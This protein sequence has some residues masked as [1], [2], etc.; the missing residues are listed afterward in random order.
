[1]VQPIEENL[2]FILIS[3]QQKMNDGNDALRL[4]AKN[5]SNLV[6]YILNCAIVQT[7]G[8]FGLFGLPDNAELSEKY[9][10]IV[11]P[12]GWAFAIWGLIYT[13][14]AIVVVAQML[15]RFRAHPLIQEGVSFWYLAACLAQVGWTFA[16]ALEV[17][18]LSL[19]LMVA[20]LVALFAIS[21]RQY[22]QFDNPENVSNIWDFWL[23]IFPFELHFGWIIC[24]TA[25]NTNVVAVSMNQPAAIQL[26]VGIISLAVLHAVALWALYVPCRPQYTIPCV[27]AWANRAIASELTDPKN[28]VTS[29]FNDTIIEAVRLSSA[30]VSIVVLILIGVRLTISMHRKFFR[31]G[32]ELEIGTDYVLS[33]SEERLLRG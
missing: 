5:Y 24:A 8:S 25:V 31:V 16:F 9:Q 3:R 19:V 22:Y 11:T 21:Y 28:L 1:V 10:T 26:F 32:D 6:G 15:P 7:I 33:R 23:L 30:F 18:W 27:I 12:A 20:I 2:R 4:N 17:M 13:L 29:T 14:Q